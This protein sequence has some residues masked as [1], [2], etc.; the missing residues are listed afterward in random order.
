MDML[1][2]PTDV[3]ALPLPGTAVPVEAAFSPDGRVLTFLHDPGGGLRRR[4]FVLDLDPSRGGPG[5]TGAREVPV[6]A[7][8]V[9][10]D[11]ELGPEE[12]LRRERAREVGFGVTTA[13]WATGGDALLVPL[14]DGLHVVHGL[15]A[16]PESP[17]SVRAVAADELP[18]APV[19]PRL[20]PDGSQ[21]AFSAAGDLYV[22]PTDG[23]GPARRLTTTAVDGLAN[24]VAEFVAQEEMG[25]S[26]GLWWSPDGA[27][28]AYAEVDERH[29]PPYRIVHQGSDRTGP[30]AEESHR[31]PFAGAANAVVRLGVLPAAG[32]RTAWMDTGDPDRYLARVHWTPSG[33]LLAQLESRDQTGLHLLALDP[34]GGGATTVHVERGEPWVNLHD[35]FRPLADG[36]FLWSSERTG[37]RH[38]EVR[39]ADGALVRVLTEGSWQV[40][41]VEAVDEDGDLV[42][43]SGRADGVRQRHLY[44]VPLSGGAVRRLTP[45]PGTHVAAVSVAAGL[46]VDRHATLADPPTV[47]VRSL[48]DA[49]V[50][51]TLHDRRDPRIDDLGL[52]PPEPVEV[53]AD[54]GTVLHGLLYRAQDPP[55]TP[56]PLV[57]AVY[58]GPHVQ[59]AVDDWGPTVAMRAQALRQRGVS[60]L[61]VDNRGSANRGLDFERPVWRRLGQLEVADQVA[62]VRWAVGAG[63]ADPDRV[64]VYGWSYGGYMALRCLGGAPDVFRAAV[65][66]AP[67]TSWDGYDTH[68]T[69]RY[70]GTPQDNTEG[71]EASSALAVAGSVR[72]RLLLVHG[73]L[74]ENVHFRHTARLLNRLVAA[75]A[76]HDLLLFPDERHLPRGV[77][78]R[79]YM[80]ERVIGWLLRALGVADRRGQ[81]GED[82]CSPASR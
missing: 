45:E 79:A 59:L 81:P 10:S 19:G 42:V 71:Y 1:L 38:L 61:T 52:V 14:P 80:E 26:H 41:G 74:D 40:D 2:S 64:G 70:M 68:Y 34:D 53:P 23:S 25:R 54:D 15:S 28:L 43:F 11:A 44:A 21:V 82:G 77:A 22:A 62:G 18:G 20:S 47:R 17:R 32:G 46:F 35:D 31:Y 48:A 51:A 60:V 76:P 3:A 58:G 49:T 27:R 56:P 7:A 69:E 72:G 30:A 33:R 24:G 5:A 75:G 9:T 8:G 6:G 37:T 4:L 73:L 57:V 63:L 55:S 36:G 66:G 67:V 29:V 65:A 39:A 78:D 12:R 13:V 16:D 50:V